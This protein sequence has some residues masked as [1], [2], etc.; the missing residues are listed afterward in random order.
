MKTQNTCLLFLS[1]LLFCY[2]GYYYSY[3]RPIVEGFATAKPKGNYHRNY[4][5]KFNYNAVDPVEELPAT[6]CKKPNQCKTKIKPL[7]KQVEERQEQEDPIT[8][9]E[10]I[11]TDETPPTPTCKPKPKPKPKCKPKPPPKCKPKPK[12]A[13]TC[14]TPSPKAETKCP[15]Y[16]PPPPK[17]KCTQPKCGTP[18]IQGC[19][20]S[21]IR[22]QSKYGKGKCDNCECPNY[23]DMSKYM[24]KSRVP[25]TPDMSQYIHKK[26][27]DR[28]IK[29]KR[30]ET[31]TVDLSKYMLKSKIPSCPA[32]PD[33]SKYVMKTSVPPPCKKCLDD[34]CGRPPAPPPK[35]KPRICCPRK[36]PPPEYEPAGSCCECEKP[37][38][39]IAETHPEEE[40]THHVPV[41]VEE[42]SHPVPPHQE[43]DKGI[44]TTIRHY[45]EKA[46]V[47]KPFFR[48][49][50]SSSGEPVALQ[51]GAFFK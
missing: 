31:P 36:P 50:S 9:E 27:L 41:I 12:P 8:V 47:C 29:E 40:S 2:I 49:E 48:S 28:I 39:P 33:M 1:L 23:P 45:Q 5:S 42:E 16:I 17:E 22:P 44:N 35:P 24:L 25:N 18:I 15:R 43:I 6:A 10:I 51:S 26:D 37:T 13:P 20:K 32:M 46:P 19:E 21:C 4:N 11:V 14:T 38:T 7:Y 30:K 34:P 3:E